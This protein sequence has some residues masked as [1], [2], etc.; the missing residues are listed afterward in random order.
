MTSR[1]K[2]TFINIQWFMIYDLWLKWNELLL[3]ALIYG[4]S[5]DWKN[6]Y[7][8]SLNYISK[9]L[10]ITKR[11]VINVLR[12]LHKRQLIIK[13]KES[14]YMINIENSIPLGGEKSIPLGGEK[15]IPLGGEKSIPNNNKKIIIINN[16]IL[17]ILDYWNNKNIIIHN[18]LTKSLEKSIKHKIKSFNILEIKKWID[19]YNNIL[20]HKNTFFKYKWTLQEFLD[21]KN[22]FNVFL[23]KKVE[24]YLKEWKSKNNNLFII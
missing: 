9:W 14:N 1:W 10:Q 4:Y 7:H 12:K 24:D 18:K 16:N 17:D 2:I 3:Y 6:T 15:S 11:S 22:W 13:T 21:R 5:Q 20:K 19:T 23:Y 8:W